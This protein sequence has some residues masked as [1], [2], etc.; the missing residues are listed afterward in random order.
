VIAVTIGN[1]LAAIGSTIA[2]LVAN[3]QRQCKHESQE[4]RVGSGFRPVGWVPG[5]Q[6]GIVLFVD[7]T[8]RM[9]QGSALC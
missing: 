5:G 8:G 7:G 2:T 9:P 3:R 1:G 4:E 6:T